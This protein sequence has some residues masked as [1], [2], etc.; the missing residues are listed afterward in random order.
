MMSNTAPNVLV[1][2]SGGPSPVINA[3]LQGVIDRCRR[4][5]ERFGTVLAGE[6]GIEGVLREELLDLDAEDPEEIARL[7]TTPSAGAIGSCRYKLHD[8]NTEDFQRII[9]VI[10]AHRVGWFFYIGGNDSMDTAAK[11]SALAQ[12]QGLDVR[13]VGIPKTIDN[14]V[15][16]DAFQMVDHT[17]G[18]GS[19]A[20]YWALI[21]QI[22]NQENLS[23]RT[24]EPVSVFQ[25]MGRR[26]G[27]IPA[28]ARLADP[29]RALP[30][31]I[32]TAESGY[33]LPA[34]ADFVSDD[35]R[36][37]GRCIVV[38][39]EGFDV[40]AA[41]GLGEAHDAFGHVEYG[42]SRN[43]VAQ[44]VVNYL[45]D[46]G[47]PVRGNVTGQ[48]PGILQRSTSIFASSVDIDE[49][50]RVGEHAVEL[51]SDGR[52]GIMAALQRVG[53]GLAAGDHPYE[54]RLGE[55][56]LADVANFHRQLPAAWI[57]PHRPDVTDAFVDYAMPLIGAQW[58]PTELTAGTQRFARFRRVRVPVTLPAYVPQNHR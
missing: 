35:L 38:V 34:M 31:Q 22:A 27:F 50:Y 11:V 36:R 37:H 4:E 25:A 2:Q 51:A 26:A 17:P 32:Y 54:V 7:R 33:G 40:S 47:L 13:V 45:N 1:A 58:A 28:A 24:S 23:M 21:T 46:R 41:G 44:Q 39:S 15:G 8:G 29:E 56:P 52:S 42:A 3:S 9:D 10:R 6:H 14:D 57:D 12:S 19:T 16:D 18:Y 53:G 5:P 49:A 43:T 48:V 55:V 30:L 20:R